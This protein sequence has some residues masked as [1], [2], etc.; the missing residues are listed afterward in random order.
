M[1]VTLVYFNKSMQD[2]EL[3][4]RLNCLYEDGEDFFCVT[5]V[6]KNECL[7]HEFCPAKIQAL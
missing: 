7:S 5:K 2:D 1:E 6:T 3:L 4:I